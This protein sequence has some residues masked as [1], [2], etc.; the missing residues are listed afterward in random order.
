MHSEQGEGFSAKD[1]KRH[2]S[3]YDVV[4]SKKKLKR[5]IKNGVNTLE[6]PL[7]NAERKKRREASR[8]LQ[9][10]VAAERLHDGKSKEATQLMDE[11]RE[12]NDKAESLS[13]S[14]KIL[15]RAEER[16]RE[17]AQQADIDIH[18]NIVQ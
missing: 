8:E 4:E 16:E 17:K 14:E 6:D 1:Q 18:G 10:K 12:T 9:E 13:S 5:E 2:K 3:K 15:R 7:Q 11:G